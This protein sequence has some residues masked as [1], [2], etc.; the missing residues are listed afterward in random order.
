MD[1]A[2]PIRPLPLFFA[3]LGVLVLF[4]QPGI[5]FQDE[6]AQ[7]AGLRSLSEGHYLVH[8]LPA[9]YDVPYF[10][11]WAILNHQGQYLAPVGSTPLNLLALPVFFI[12]KT[13][14]GNGSIWSAF[15]FVQSILLGTGVAAIAHLS[16]RWRHVAPGAGIVVGTVCWAA[17]GFR[18]V[19]LT[20]APYLEFAALEITNMVLAAAGA[21]LL[22]HVANRH[23]GQ[24]AALAACLLYLFAT[25]AFLWAEAAK[26]HALGM[27]LMVSLAWAY[28]RG[29]QTSPKRTALACAICLLLAWTYFPFG[30]V[31]L[32]TFA[33][34]SL[35]AWRLGF[36]PA[37]QRWGSAAGVLVLAGIS[38][39][40]MR[41]LQG[42]VGEQFLPQ[43]SGGRIDFADV[44]LQFDPGNSGGWIGHS[45]FA[46]PMG[47]MRAFWHLVF[48]ADSQQ[49]GQPL[50][51]LQATPWAFATVAVLAKKQ[52]RQLM[53]TAWRWGLC[54]YLLLLIALLGETLVQPGGSYD[55]R[56]AA[57]LWPLIVLVSL[58]LIASMQA[59]WSSVQWRSAVGAFALL[60]GITALATSLVGH[61]LVGHAFAGGYGLDHIAMFR[62]LGLFGVVLTGWTLFAPQKPSRTPWVVSI[63]IGFSLAYVI[64]VQIT[65]AK[66]SGA[67]AHAPFVS[68]LMQGLH[69]VA[70]AIAYHFV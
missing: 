65:T 3:L 44:A 8:D 46:D 40:L 68:Q 25:P 37:V 59:L 66:I 63:V 53:P 29:G 28:E 7:A 60:F 12:L 41:L 34:L 51:L 24:R 67:G 33:L 15:G 16:P 58:P 36:M 50:A 13:L 14:A 30:V 18:E 48:W 20:L 2:P 21:V 23:V 31:A 26:Y 11:H 69:D 5:I 17:S 57:Y 42:H 9:G 56:Y 1:E 54:I 10:G 38:F 64:T 6:T 4:W 45:V 62:V 61:L 19:Q 35:S 55:M 49:S 27:A 32:V 22:F 47:T 70:M 43:V 52:W 39:W